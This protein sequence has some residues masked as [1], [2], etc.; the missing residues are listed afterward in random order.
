[1]SPVESEAKLSA[2]AGFSL[3]DLDGTAGL[4][5]VDAHDR[6]LDALYFDTPD[7][8]L[9]GAGATLRHRT[10]E[11][12]AMG[13]WTLKLPKGAT[14]RGALRRDELDFDG[15]RDARPA[16]VDTAVDEFVGDGTAEQ[17]GTI[18][19]VRTQRHIVELETA[20]G[21]LAGEIDV[22]HVRVADPTGA[23]GGE[24]REIEVELHSAG[25]DALLDAVVDRLRAAGAG[26]MDPT[27]KV[28]RALDLLGLVVRA[29]GTVVWRA[30]NGGIEVLVV[31]RPKYDDWSLPK[32][33]L[34]P[35]E[36]DE[37]CAVRETAEETGYVV[38]LG[39]ELPGASYVDRKRR[40][41]TVRYWEATVESGN[42][43]PCT[44]VDD[45]RWLSPQDAAERLSYP[46]DAEVVA[47]LAVARS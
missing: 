13:R 27:P 18:A 45:A 1:M 34:E 10:G 8:R 46:R 25:D 6:A 33:K 41:K 19:I 31:H 17:L 7:Y 37:E 30:G 3:P 4:R 24:F 9:L 42:F 5:A 12:P 14:R 32:G 39:A 15:A 2:P 29:S 40:P 38:R 43:V 28:V 36:T 11:G 16:A 35:G 44:E 22:D 26:A 47:A 20:D 21:V 23:D